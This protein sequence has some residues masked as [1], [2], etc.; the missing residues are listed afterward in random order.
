LQNVLDNAL[1]YSPDDQPCEVG[2]RE[3]DGFV[4]F[5][6]RD[7]GS[8]IPRDQL[9]NIFKPFYQADASNTRSHSGVGLGLSIVQRLVARLG[10]QIDVQSTVGKGTIFTVRLPA[11]HSSVEAANAWV[12]RIPSYVG[13][14]RRSA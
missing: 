11:A 8:G 5:W 12:V 6:V 1:K 3:Q 9:E 4:V 14:S 10:G 13:E 7:R 2:A